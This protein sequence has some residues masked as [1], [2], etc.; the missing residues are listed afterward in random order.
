[1]AEQNAKHDESA[2]ALRS[3]AEG[4]AK[5]DSQDTPDPEPS[6]ALTA[7]ATG[8]GLEAVGEGED[9]QQTDRPPAGANETQEQGAAGGFALA[10][11]TDQT[12]LLNSG[13]HLAARRARATHKS[14][15][16]HAHA[17]QFKQIMAPLLLVVGL[18]LFVLGIIVALSMPG[19]GSPEARDGWPTA[20]AKVAVVIAFPLGAVL[21]FGAWYFHRE[22]KQSGKK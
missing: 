6:D 13:A 7:M 3:M 4:A 1:M 20:S 17:H 8:H 9:Q 2:D 14:K 18:M 16:H 5:A 15:S 10:G 19:G 21:L 11:P 12:S 22:V